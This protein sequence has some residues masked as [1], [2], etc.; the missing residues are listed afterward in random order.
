MLASVKVLNYPNLL[1][2]SDL[3]RHPVTTHRALY[4][5]ILTKAACQKGLFVRH[6][7][8]LRDYNNLNNNIKIIIMRV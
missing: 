3:P 5:A 4:T 6:K 7:Y 8:G 1:T 2:Q